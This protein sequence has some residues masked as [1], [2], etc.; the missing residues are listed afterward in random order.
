MKISKFIYFALFAVVLIL[1][2]RIYKKDKSFVSRKEP[3]LVFAAAGTASAMKEIAADFTRESGV[4]VVYNFA[5]A[6]VLAKQINAGA[7]AHI[8]FSANDKWM[9]AV[10]QN[11]RLDSSSRFVLL[12]NDLVVIVPKGGNIDASVLC[13]PNMFGKFDGRLAL[14]DESTPV[15]IYARQSLT[16]LGWWDSLK[17]NICCG[18]T[19]SKVLYYVALREAAAGVV[20]RS[21][22]QMSDKVEIACTLPAKTHD[23]IYFPIAATTEFHAGSRS[24]LSFVQ[25][26]KAVEVFKKY[27]WRKQ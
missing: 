6:G 24:F 22:A 4:P 21:L 14:G 13:A 1:S 15:G 20:F 7:K 8:F 17:G 2:L 25:G 3:L 16:R 10:E 9:D 27:G 12:K 19:V 26:E 11:G 18:D 23:P 5:N